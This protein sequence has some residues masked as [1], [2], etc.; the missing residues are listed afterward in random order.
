[1]ELEADSWDCSEQ[2]TVD[3]QVHL[4]LMLWQMAHFWA[5]QASNGAAKV[6]LGV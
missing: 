1:M 4:Q 3:L 6:G 5:G 2:R